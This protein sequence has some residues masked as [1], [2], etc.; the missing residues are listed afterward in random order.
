MVLKG[1][2]F[3]A[4]QLAKNIHIGPSCPRS[5]S[6]VL[7]IVS[8]EKGGIMANCKNCG[9]PL[10]RGNIRFIRNPGKRP[11][12]IHRRCPDA[13]SEAIQK[14]IDTPTICDNCSDRP[15]CVMQDPTK[16]VCLKWS[17]QRYRHGTAGNPA[18]T[19]RDSTG[20][21][22]VVEGVFDY[23][24]A[25]KYRYFVL[26]ASAEK[27]KK[28]IAKGD[29]W[30]WGFAS[31]WSMGITIEIIPVLEEVVEMNPEA[32]AHFVEIEFKA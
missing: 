20:G 32:V 7:N 11:F 22:F 28:A 2:L 15:E 9:G 30:F 29:A 8:V 4:V 10:K 26:P 27:L 12:R 23:L 1:R 18:Q 19:P 31:N 5:L 25:P 14:L 17:Q 13:H 3:V 6:I 21:P 16:R 24:P